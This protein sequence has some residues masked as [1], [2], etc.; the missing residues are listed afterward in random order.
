MNAR[1]T[2][3]TPARTAVDPVVPDAV[4]VVKSPND[5]AGPL[6]SSVVYLVDGVI[7]FTDS[8][9]L[10]LEVPTGG[11]TVF[12]HSPG[13]SRMVTS[14]PSAVMF[15]SAA[16]GDFTATGVTFTASGAG[17]TVYDLTAA[18]GSEAH[19]VERVNYV[20]C[21][22]LGSLSGFRQGFEANTGRFGG[23]P[24]LELAGAW[25]GGFFIDAMIVRGV[26]S[27][28]YSLFSEGASLSFGSRFRST[29]NVDL[30]AGVAYFDFKSS[31]FPAPSTLQLTN[32][33]IT[34]SGS[35]DPADPGI[36]PNLAAGD[37]ASFW[38]GNVGV[39]NTHVGA[40]VNMGSGSAATTF[41]AAGVPTDLV[42]TWTLS[43]A[44]HCD[45][46]SAGVSSEIRHLA[47]SP[48]EFRATAI[49]SVGGTA[50]RSLVLSIVKAASGGGDSTVV[51]Q[52]R[53]VVNLVGP[54]DVAS[55]VASAAVVLEDGD[56][57]RLLIANETD[58]SSVTCL[59]D[60]YL[61]IEER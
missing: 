15:Q 11:L 36:T 44:E 54:N 26:S 53:E 39:R 27:G 43:D 61:T 2:G 17:S 24:S 10:P 40:T 25:A 8:K 20:D 45:N 7:D 1:F 12:G 46:P 4:K 23:S 47:S 57:V 56:S 58:T 41:S 22:S 21:A 52:R 6:S 33:I 9:V 48:Q 37:L 49:V 3:A 51:A 50:G 30:P 55:F 5:M 29:A 59:V 18:T 34:R 32:G 14:A 38:K 31:V 35:I 60:S 19:E 28:G 42:G 16:S 13:V